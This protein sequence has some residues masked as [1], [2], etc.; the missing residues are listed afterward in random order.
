[1]VRINN[2]YDLNHWLLVLFFLAQLCIFVSSS[3]ASE[4][5]TLLKFK[6][7]LSNDTALDNW[8]NS[9]NP[10]NGTTNIWSGLYCE[11]NGK[12]Y[13]LKLQNMGLMG[14][15][16]ID[17][18]L[19]L[20]ALRSISIMNNNFEGPLPSLNKLGALIGVYLS[21]NQFTGEMQDNAFEGMSSL[22]KIYLDGNEFS[23]KIP[24]S[25]AALSKLS[26]LGLQGNQFS[27]KIPNFAQSPN[28][29]KYFNI[30]NNRFE[31]R[32]P[33]SLS[34]LE[35]SAFTGNL[36]LCGK[37]LAPCKSSKKKI[38]LI[39]AIV[40][41]SIAAILCTMVAIL[42]IR[43][44]SA[45]SKQEARAQKKLKAQ[46]HT[47]AMEV[48]LTADEDNYKKAEKGGELYFV[49]KDR[50]FELEE[51][52]R[53]PAE[54]L[55]SGSFGSSY[56]AGLLSGSM[57]VKRF[58]QINQVGKED[59]YDHMRRLGRLS[60]PNLL[61]LVAFYYRKEEKLLVH[62]FVA[63]GSLASHLHVKREP[64]QPGLDWPTRLMIIKGV[65]RGLGYLYKEFPGLTVPHGH[66]KSSNVLLDHNFN[67]LIA[68]YA[69][70]PVINRDHAQKFMVAY[71]SPEFSHTEQTSKKTDVWSLG[72]LIFEMLTGKF[73]ANYL[74]QGKRANAD[75]A[76]WVNSVVR[77][78]WTGEVFDK[79]MKGTKNGEG[80]MLKLLKIG[81]CC[82]ESSVEGRWDWREVVDKIEEL[83][84]RD[85]EEEYSSY[86]SDGDMGSSRAMTDD[87]FSFSVNA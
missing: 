45:K 22:K 53:A 41:V 60:H 81:M 55:G 57:V 47:A 46:H 6:S 64:G 62:D 52:L 5:Q 80:E 49:R 19:G 67:P 74:Q 65:S 85:S 43:R 27:G 68:E 18:L 42:F 31:G 48:Q 82:C 54:V 77:E 78:E 1:M 34:N 63:N 11:K 58:R 51:L 7:F 72:I 40:V 4:I 75:L 28:G 13:G 29:W 21:N 50:G 37:P 9:T 8:N 32:I 84:E 12:V 87:D 25:L 14:I 79:N 59:F 69:L 24:K 38:L 35:A 61:P 83:K 2:A 23:G 3:D 76:A 56:K 30:S 86:A 15:I 36:G 71:K 17:T 10:C 20:S 70:I 16:D 33:A 26:E 39:I 44:R 73:P 66:L